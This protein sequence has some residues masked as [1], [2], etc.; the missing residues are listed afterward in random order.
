MVL[1]SKTNKQNYF[2]KLSESRACVHN[3]QNFKKYLS[4]IDNKKTRMCSAL[5][6]IETSEYPPQE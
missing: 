4:L 2:H 6:E 3:D 5:K 1:K